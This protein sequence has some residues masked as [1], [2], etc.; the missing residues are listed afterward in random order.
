MA[1]VKLISVNRKEIAEGE[2]KIRMVFEHNGNRISKMA[3][4]SSCALAVGSDRKKEAE[5]SI[6]KKVREAERDFAFLEHGE[7]WRE[8]CG[9]IGKFWLTSITDEEQQLLRQAI[10]LLK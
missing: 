2:N 8:H 7:T 6:L 4:I 5:Y 1:L 3:Q 10:D 9:N